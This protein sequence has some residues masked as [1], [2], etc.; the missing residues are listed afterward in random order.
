M[1]SFTSGC[2]LTHTPI[3]EGAP[4]VGVFLLATGDSAKPR[5][6]LAPAQRHTPVGLP[7]RGTADGYGWLTP[8]KAARDHALPL[9]ALEMILAAGA[10]VDPLPHGGQNEATPFQAGTTDL[11]GVVAAQHRHRLFAKVTAARRPDGKAYITS[12]LCHAAA[13]DLLVQRP[14]AEGGPEGEDLTVHDRVSALFPLLDAINAYGRFPP[15]SDGFDGLEAWFPL[16]ESSSRGTGMRGAPALHHGPILAHLQ[17]A[18]YAH[19]VARDQAGRDAW[20][21]MARLLAETVHVHE[22]ML[23]ARRLWSPGVGAH[24]DEDWGL[25]SDLSALAHRLTLDGQASAASTDA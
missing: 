2:F 8:G 9:Q 3:P 23:A 13:W 19:A 25:L 18:R 12:A 1:G 22:Q 24:Q 10:F 11:Q 20:A 5:A 4:V 6:L 14:V 15:D 21:G 17:A 7:F 16:L